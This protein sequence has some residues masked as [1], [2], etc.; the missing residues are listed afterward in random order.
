MEQINILES[1]EKLFL[2]ITKYFLISF[3]ILVSVL[4]LILFL[5]L[6]AIFFLT[7]TPFQ[8]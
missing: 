4:A 2:M 3:P 8:I 5:F 6:I 1:I 7:G